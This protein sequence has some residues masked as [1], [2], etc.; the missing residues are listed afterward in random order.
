M[1]ANHYQHL[2]DIRASETS[3]KIE[4]ICHW[5]ARHNPVTVPLVT[6]NYMNCDAVQRYAVVAT[7]SIFALFP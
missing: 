6:G 5:V 7:P 2:S 4:I 1:G 3:S